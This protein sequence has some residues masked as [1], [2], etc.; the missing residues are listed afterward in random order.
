MTQ[1]FFEQQPHHWLLR[2]HAELDRA[3]NSAWAD[4]E[5]HLR[6]V[7]ADMHRRGDTF[8][9]QVGTPQEVMSRLIKRESVHPTHA[10]WCKAR[11]E[12]AAFRAVW[13]F[14]VE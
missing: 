9:L 7:I 2:R 3:A 8:E 1:R 14:S 11:E 12:A 4:F 13:P 5:D 10:A 6:G